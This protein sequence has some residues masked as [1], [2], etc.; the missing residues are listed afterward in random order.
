M[1]SNPRVLPL[2]TGASV[3]FL[4]LFLASTSFAQSVGGT[5][6]TK[7]NLD[8][9]YDALADSEEEEDAPE[10]ISFYGQQFEGDAFFYV[11]DS[12]GSMR[13]SGELNR[14]KQ[15]I[16]R[17]ITEFT[18]RVRFG[19]VFFNTNVKKFPSGGQPAEANPAQKGAAI[20]FIN[21][22]AG[23]S[24]SCCQQGMQACL[25]MANQATGAKRKVMTYVGDG[26][27]TCGGDEAQYLRQAL[28][29][30][31]SQNYQRVQ[32]NC[33]GVMSYP[34]LNEDFMRNLSSANN[35]TYTKIQ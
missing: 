24:G 13:D 32:I 29:T 21:S 33:I 27:G 35:G 25:Q 7:E 19:I 26:G 18:E 5:P 8:L 2:Y 12:S 15:E 34:K 17:N 3:L 31:T 22:E 20:G 14:A 30:I 11:V 10:I 16:T 23:A 6:A 4:A 28:A 1:P 9:P